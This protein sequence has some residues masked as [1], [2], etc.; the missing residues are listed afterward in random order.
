MTRTSTASAKAANN[1]AVEVK[2]KVQGKGRGRIAQGGAAPSPAR[3]VVTPG[4]STPG[5]PM[6]GGTTPGGSVPGGSKPGGSGVVSCLS[7]RS[8]IGADTHALQCERCQDP[9]AW[10]C[11]SCIGMTEDEYELLAAPLGKSLHWFCDSC[12]NAAL[13]KHSID[14]IM[15][16]LDQILKQNADMMKQMQEKASIDTVSA[17]GER[18]EKL[19][20]ELDMNSMAAC[21][22]DSKS[23]DQLVMKAVASQSEEENEIERRK[24]NIII[25]R[26]PEAVTDDR[27]TRQAS[28]QAFFSSLCEET[29][30][31]GPVQDKFQSMVRLGKMRS[32]GI[33]RPLLVKLDTEATKTKL[34]S[35]LKKLNTAEEK[36]RR[37]SIA[38]DLT[39]KQREMRKAALEE[40][41][42]QQETDNATNDQQQGNWIFR[43]VGQL[44]KPRVIRVRK[45]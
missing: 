30:S 5:G 43:V 4:G 34:M 26:V 19:E 21:N 14:E 41:K 1:A 6:P 28:D 27:D 16:K 38:H 23:V 15:E 8:V 31:I 3:S 25:Y 35:N 33:A 7:C 37:I 36:F 11:I 45:N 20:R 12:E 9:V 40:A 44:N 18:L 24:N 42:L 10:K 29:L 22:K 32:D 13:N 39:V 2:A 17:L